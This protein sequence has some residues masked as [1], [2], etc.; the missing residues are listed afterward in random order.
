MSFRVVYVSNLIHVRAI[1]P[2]VEEC[3]GVP[4]PKTHIY[5]LEIPSTSRDDGTIIGHVPNVLHQ[6]VSR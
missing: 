1:C 2:K 5:L 6:N 4:K 3:G